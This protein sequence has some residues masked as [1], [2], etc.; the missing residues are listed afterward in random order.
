MYILKII[1]IILLSFIFSFAMWYLIFWF[2]TAEDNLF[3]WNGW[4]KA[5]YL[6]LAFLSMSGIADETFKEL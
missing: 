2:I 3:A 6:F 4:T 1:A 5:A